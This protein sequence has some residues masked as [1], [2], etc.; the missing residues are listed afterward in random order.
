MRMMRM[1]R[2]MI[3]C[4]YGLAELLEPTLCSKMGYGESQWKKE[5]YYTLTNCHA[6]GYVSFLIFLSIDKSNT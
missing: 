4:G 3:L 1:M 2:M 6:L 5:S